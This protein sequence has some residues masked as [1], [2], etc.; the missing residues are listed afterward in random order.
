LAV[1]LLARL[2]EH[3]A[4]RVGE[5]AGDEL[6]DA[7]ITKATRLYTAIMSRL[8]NRDTAT[9]DA[10]ERQPGR[11]DLQREAATVI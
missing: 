8:T 11:E 6:T 1:A 10:L 4:G 5:R 3:M 2:F 9:L 7:T